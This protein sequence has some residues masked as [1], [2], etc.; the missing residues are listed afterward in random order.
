MNQFLFRYRFYM[1]AVGI[2][3]LGTGLFLV[4]LH[5]EKQASREVLPVKAIEEL[6]EIQV[7]DIAEIE[8]SYGGYAVKLKQKGDVW[9]L[10]AEEKPIVIA[11][12]AKVLQLLEEISKAKLLRELTIASEEEAAALALGTGTTAKPQQTGCNVILRD[13]NG[14]TVREMMLGKVHYSVGEQIGRYRTN[15][16]DG[17]YVRIMVGDAPHYFLMSKPMST[18]T[19]F[20]AFWHN[21]VLCPNMGIPILVRYTDLANKKILWEVRLDNNKHILAVPKEKKL[22]VKNMQ[23]KLGYLTQAPLSRD[24]AQQKITFKPDSRLDIIYANGFSYSLE[25]Q[26][27]L[28][29]EWNRF[30]RLTPAYD[31]E[32]TF[33]KPGETKDAFEKRKKQYLAEL[34]REKKLFGGQIF[35]LRPNLINIFETVPGK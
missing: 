24:I 31:P 17:R 28:F 10:H 11:D 34:A 9:H 19:P 4:A 13:K 20:S 14:N 15:I 16:P 18:C 12:P 27:D 21:P 3:L 26:N 29:D 5:K 30:G 35:V 7:Q 25:M 32:F 1:I 33:Q 23:E 6:P 22:N 2:I 8:I